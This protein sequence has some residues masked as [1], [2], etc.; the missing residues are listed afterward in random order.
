MPY[1][2]KDDEFSNWTL[3]GVTVDQAVSRLSVTLRDRGF[4]ILGDISF[5]KLLR[6]KTGKD[7]EPIRMLEVCKPPIALEALESDRRLAHVMPCRFTLFAEPTGVSI[8]LYRPTAAMKRISGEAG[9]LASAVEEE[10]AAA[11]DQV[12]TI[13]EVS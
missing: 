4:G 5:D 3:E 6:E 2:M 9:T 8:S 7:I 12:V 10:L 11:V 13:S 1:N